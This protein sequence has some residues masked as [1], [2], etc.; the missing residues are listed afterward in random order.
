M[1]MTVPRGRTYYRGMV[2]SRQVLN[3]DHS[4]THLSSLL[5]WLLIDSDQDDG[6]WSETVLCRG[7]HILDHVL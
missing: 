4:Q 2:V 5:E 1:Q 3:C 6:V 7:L